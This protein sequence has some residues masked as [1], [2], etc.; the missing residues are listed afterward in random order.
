MTESYVFVPLTDPE[1]ELPAVARLDQIVA[2]YPLRQG[3]RTNT[4]IVLASGDMNLLVDEAP[5][6]VLGIVDDLLRRI[7]EAKR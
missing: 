2:M 5:G 3:A 6:E 1:T 7:D 4:V